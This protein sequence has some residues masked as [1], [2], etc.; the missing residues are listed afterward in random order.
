MILRNGVEGLK[1]VLL[2][3]LQG[4]SELLPISSSGHI[5]L[6]KEYLGLDLHS[7]PFIIWLHM[8]SL[9]A[10]IV[11]F[12]KHIKGMIVVLIRGVIMRDY[13]G[14]MS[15]HQGRLSLLILL[16]SLPIFL[17]GPLIRDPIERIF[18]LPKFVSILLIVNG[19]ILWAAERFSPLKTKRRIG[20]RDALLI[21]CA[22]VIGVLPGI[23]RSGITITTGM[24]IGIEREVV[25]SYSF[26]LAILA[27][28]GACVMEIFCGF[29]LLVGKGNLFYYLLGGLS[30]FC[31]SLLS[32][33]FLFWVLR[34]RR[35]H[36]FSIYCFGIG[37]LMLVGEWVGS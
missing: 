37:L 10:I 19:M 34:R 4:I 5:V 25:A 32:L 13:S 29:H 31:L 23:S 28:L 16:G 35:L 12:W 36:L 2:G 8:G 3:L 24:L 17:L 1:V 21:G 15:S 7:L 18:G 6:L 20:M 30:A 27:I 33:R 11:F 9:F 22:Q 14:W 26:F